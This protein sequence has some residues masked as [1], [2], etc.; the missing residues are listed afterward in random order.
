M[1]S[2][3]RDTACIPTPLQ[4]SHSRFLA[5]ART[6]VRRHAFF[7]FK[8][9]PKSVP[10]YGQNIMRRP[11]LPP[12]G[13][14]IT[15]YLDLGDHSNR[16]SNSHALVRASKAEQQALNCRE[17]CW[18]PSKH[19]VPSVWTACDMTSNVHSH[20]RAPGGLSK[21]RRSCARPRGL[22]G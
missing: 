14:R 4:A 16:I 11:L 9:R 6:R 22:C 19:T 7:S 13:R 2:G 5:S 18:V 1:L 20:R 8:P 17:T 21:W 3:A 10:Q 12:S 15:Q